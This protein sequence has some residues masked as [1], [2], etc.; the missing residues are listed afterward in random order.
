MLSL[1][2]SSTQMT[3]QGCLSAHSGRTHDYEN[4]EFS[5]DPELDPGSAAPAESLQIYEPG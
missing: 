5:V 4:D 3:D 2:L 1:P